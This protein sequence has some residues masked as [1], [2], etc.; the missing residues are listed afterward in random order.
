LR[1]EILYVATLPHD[2]TLGALDAGARR[3]LAET[4]LTLTRQAYRHRGV[5]NDPERAAR[6]KAE[7]VGYAH[8]RHHQ[9]ALAPLRRN[10][11][12]RFDTPHGAE[13]DAIASRRAHI[14]DF[15]C[16]DSRG[17]ITMELEDLDDLKTIAVG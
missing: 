10:F 13:R 12:D 3:R 4:A 9:Y 5:T 2:L 8:Y 14:P 17:R 7:G 1:S 16:N 15:A 6:L 11:A